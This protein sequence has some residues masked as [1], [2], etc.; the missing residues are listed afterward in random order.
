MEQR[1]SPEVLIVQL[2][3][4]L[5]GEKENKKDEDKKFATP[6]K[7]IEI[8]IRKILENPPNLENETLF[9]KNDG[10]TVLHAAVS[11]LVCTKGNDNQRA[12]LKLLISQ[13]P[14][15]IKEDR[16]Q[17]SKYTGQTP[18]HMAVCKG[19]KWLVKQMI[20]ALTKKE[21]L[22][23]IW[24]SRATGSIF[25]NTAMMGELPFTVAAL[26]TNAG[27]NFSYA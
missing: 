22:A 8:K 21:L 24:K 19:S 26:T 25:Y 11:Q 13:L 7:R 15:L 1:E 12:I 2:R 14:D 20:A 16:R 9:K 10:E 6:L 3:D 23:E 18:F 5:V 4:D 17:S 27:N